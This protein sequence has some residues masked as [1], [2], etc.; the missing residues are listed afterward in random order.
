MNIE[1]LIP[2][3]I[4]YAALTLGRIACH[5]AHMGAVVAGGTVAALAKVLQEGPEVPAA[6]LIK[7]LLAAIKLVAK[8]Q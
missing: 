4:E 3:N 2:E 1:F 7:Q 8:L 5:E 6:A